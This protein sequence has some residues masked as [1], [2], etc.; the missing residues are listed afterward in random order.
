MTNE[1]KPVELSRNWW[2]YSLH[3]TLALGFLT[4]A[5]LISG[6]FNSVVFLL[7]LLLSFLIMI[8]MVCLGVYIWISGNRFVN[9]L[10]NQQFP[11][12]LD[13]SVQD[14]DGFIVN[15]SLGRFNTLPYSG[16]DILIPFFIAKKYA[17]KI[18]HCYNTDDFT[19][20][21]KNEKVRYLWIFGHGWRGGITFKW[22]RKLSCLLMRNRS[23]ISYYKICSELE[24]CPKKKFIGLF[25][26]SHLD[27]SEPDNISAPE[28]LLDTSDGS[29][30]YLTDGKMN[31]ISIWFA[32]RK[33]INDVKRTE[34]SETVTADDHVTSGCW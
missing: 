2:Y 31:T 10:T 30:Y 15:H 12:N 27:R 5:I 11:R 1:Y 25:H 19:A 6:L 24:N 34:I 22:T 4:F 32:I 18:Y 9:S 8:S 20:V 23:R 17:F 14:H 28:L 21:L 16:F 7:I 26:C 3:L 29:T 13:T 33:C